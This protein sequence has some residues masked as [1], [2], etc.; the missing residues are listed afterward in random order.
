[1]IVVVM[2][3]ILAAIAYPSYQEQVRKARRGVAKADLL[4]LTQGFERQFTASRDYRTF[5]PPPATSP[6]VAWTYVTSPRDAAANKE[7]Y[8]LSVSAATTATTYSIKAV[9][10]NSQSTDRCGTLTI[11]NLGQKRH[12]GSGDDVYCA[13]GTLATP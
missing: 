10:V 3:A 4:E 8:D 12:G 5:I 1:M 11:D 6:N 9:P 13:W 2:V 7:Y